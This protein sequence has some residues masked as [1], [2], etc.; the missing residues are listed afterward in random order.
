MAKTF[1][2]QIGVYLDQLYSAALCFTLDEHRAEELLQEAAIR[3]FHEYSGRRGDEDFRHFMLQILVATYLKR[4]RSM[5]SDP[6]ASEAVIME[7][8]FETRQELPG[9]FP[10]PGSS[11]RLFM[12]RWMRGVWVELDDGDRVVLWLADIERLRHRRVAA[13]TGLK[14][15]EV[16]WRHYRA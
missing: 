1:E 3:A 9:P 8:V 10:P 6:L 11:A 12:T 15:T 13:L 16:R 7:E 5:G 14:V 4:R 2:E